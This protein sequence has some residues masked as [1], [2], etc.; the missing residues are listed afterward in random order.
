MAP[1][2]GGMA[3]RGGGT[4]EREGG[5]ARS[6]RAGLQRGRKCA[7]K[8]GTTKVAP[9]GARGASVESITNA[10]HSPPGS[11]DGARPVRGRG[12]RPAG[13]RVVG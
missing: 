10:G 12:P 9:S 4:R 2:P 3:G 7:A 6:M 1:S 13:V 8:G 5:T 11:R